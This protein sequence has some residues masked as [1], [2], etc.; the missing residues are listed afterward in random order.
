MALDLSVL[1]MGNDVEWCNC[2][3][4]ET[5]VELEVNWRGFTSDRTQGCEFWEATAIRRSSATSC[6]LLEKLTMNVFW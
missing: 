3:L 4:Y 1:M 2:C 5:W 6:M